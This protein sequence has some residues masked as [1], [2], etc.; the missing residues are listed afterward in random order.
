LSDAAIQVKG[1]SKDF[2]IY[3]K[4]L[5]VAIEVLSGRIRRKRFRALDNVSFEVERGEIMGVIG[6]NGAGKSTLLK[7]ITG[8]LD[9]TEGTVEIRGRVTAILELGLGFNG[10]LSGRE[11][12]QLSGLLY[13]MTKS[14]IE[15]KLAGIIEFS[16]LGDFIDRP[17][18]IY[19]SGMQAR[20]AF[21]VA[22]AV[23]PDILII[24]EAL[25]A[26]D[27]MFVQKSM[28]RIYELCRGG[29]TVL[30]VSHGTGILAQ[31][32]QR[33]M[34]L[35]GGKIRAIGPA[36]NVI[37]AYDLAAHQGADSSSWI[38]SVTLPAKSEVAGAATVAPLLDLAILPV[39]TPP[40]G[41]SDYHVADGRQVLRRG[42]V[43]IDSVELLDPNRNPTT[44]VTSLMPCTI[45][46]NYHCE[47]PIPEETV[48][49]ALSINQGG[50]LVPVMQWYT[51]NIKP[52]ET[53]ESYAASNIRTR[54]YRR[55]VIEL[56]FLR[57]PFRAG[58]YHLSVGL[59]PNVPGSW[60]F[61]E[62][63]H[64]F[65]TFLVVD[66]GLG[67]GAFTFIE[68]YVV[69]CDGADAG[70]GSSRMPGPQ[71]GTLRDEIREI[72]FS[73]GR[74]PLGWPAHDACP[75]CGSTTLVASF[76]KDDMSHRRCGACEFVFLDPYPPDWV[77]K[78]LYAG[79]YY[80][81][82]REL[83]ESPR[84][85][86]GGEATPFSAPAED[87]DMIIEACT[88]DRASGE[89]LDV[90]GGIGAFAGRIAK[91]RPTWKVELNEF[92]PRSIEIAKSVLGV[93]AR[94]DDAA[95]LAAEGRTYDVISFVMVIEHIVQPRDII[96]S[97]AR[98]LKPGGYLAIVVPNFT[99][100]SAHVAGAA[101]ASA[102]P[103]FHVSL[104]NRANFERMLWDLGLF[105]EIKITE[106]GPAAFSL[107]HH[108]AVSEYF[109]VSMPTA[110]RPMPTTIMRAPYEYEVGQ[111]VAVLAE[112]N[113]KL[114]S[115]FA[116]QDGR[117]W[118]TAI[119]KVPAEEI[120]PSRE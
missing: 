3:S 113:T 32:C 68:P 117:L 85:S 18:K 12:I 42:P 88:K 41:P 8:V 31:L 92:N 100:L 97:Y 37:Q 39:A 64:F 70:D 79:R 87:L 81:N 21:S 67:I 95:A 49:V 58:T 29:R 94:P 14:E 101:S 47:G 119:A 45:R 72:C 11:N 112:A 19:S 48:G 115:Y 90:G 77:I 25:A 93:S 99:P 98:L 50:D 107:I 62:Y 105:A 102:A 103:P 10:E 89:W 66:R 104:F 33:V 2:D 9:A 111:R 108:V 20:L 71:P 23:D 16:G 28:R 109:D 78:E 1:L 118:L 114:G 59:L 86:K 46:I 40:S 91:A 80:T 30:V 4:P 38:E 61:W 76:S 17:V 36:M 7:I 52:D 75:C 106:T 22:T 44:S 43:F 69:H 15:G 35:D 34:W 82:I 73:K 96:T 54:A 83:F 110:G 5:D 55:G 27:A 53:R 74:Y 60:W 13:G 24:D 6:H 116:E 65:Y 120:S 57:V 84:L 51:H 63:R 56:G 26:G